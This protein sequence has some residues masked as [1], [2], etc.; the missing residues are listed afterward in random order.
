ME[1]WTSEKV[2][3]SVTRILYNIYILQK[4]LTFHVFGIVEIT[5]CS[6]EYSANI[7]KVFDTKSV[8]QV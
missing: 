2:L 1:L 4:L 6:I 7:S 8:R 5:F 3:L